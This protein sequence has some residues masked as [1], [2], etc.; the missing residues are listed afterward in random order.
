MTPARAISIGEYIIAN[1]ILEGMDSHLKLSVNVLRARG[2]DGERR[3][4]I[5]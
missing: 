1:A 4:A 2:D 3:V 5:D